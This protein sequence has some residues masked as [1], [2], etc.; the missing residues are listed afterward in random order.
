[1]ALPPPKAP[2]NP[3]GTLNHPPHPSEPP[4]VL[5]SPV[6]YP[7]LGHPNPPTPSLP[8]KSKPPRPHI[9]SHRSG[10]PTPHQEP[11]YGAGA[12]PAAWGC[13]CQHISGCLAAPQRPAKL[14]AHR[15]V[16]AACGR[17][18]LTKMACLPPPDPPTPLKGLRG[19]PQPSLS[20]GATGSCGHP[21]GLHPEA[22]L[23]L[24]SPPSFFLL[25][26]GGS[27]SRNYWGGG[28]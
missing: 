5:R 2:P 25:H 10:S 28:G 26:G 14:C 23:L 4:Q 21:K 20:S 3:M 13:V 18:T 9:S 24:G 19:S 22:L 16:T 15:H 7:P 17:P 6:P 12:P 11:R 8:P 1:M 27:A